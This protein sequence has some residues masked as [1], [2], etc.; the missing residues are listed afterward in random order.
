MGDLEKKNLNSVITEFETQKYQSLGDAKTKSLVEIFNF[1]AKQ[2]IAQGGQF[3][4]IKETMQEINLGDF[5]IFCKD[6]GIQLPKAKLSEV[7]KKQQINNKNHKFDQF[8]TSLMK[9]GSQLNNLKLE[10]TLNRIKEINS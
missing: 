9:V 5:I 4:E 8:V 10:E 2:H 3:D 7:Y 6:F 1:Y